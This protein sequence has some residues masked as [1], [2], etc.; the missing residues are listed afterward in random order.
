MA[1]KISALCLIGVEKVVSARSFSPSA[2]ATEPIRLDVSTANISGFGVI[3]VVLR[4][5]FN[6]FFQ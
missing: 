1:G 2:I 6:G 3:G 4:G 5:V